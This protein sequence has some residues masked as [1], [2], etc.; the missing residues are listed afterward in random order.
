MK[1]TPEHTEG[2][3]ALNL[4]RP[5]RAYDVFVEEGMAEWLNLPDMPR[6]TV[7]PVDNRGVAH[8]P[9]RGKGPKAV[10]NPEQKECLLAGQQADLSMTSERARE[11]IQLITDAINRDWPYGRPSFTFRTETVPQ[12]ECA[13]EILFFPDAHDPSTEQQ[14]FMQNRLQWYL[15]VL[16][17]VSK[18]LASIL[19]DEVGFE[20]KG[21]DEFGFRVL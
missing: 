6:V 10:F 12:V 15:D 1:K 7:C 9:Y 21:L 3:V 17:E 14:E 2:P 19:G 20:P 4:S 5:V 18:N 16:K 11:A 8:Q 13:P